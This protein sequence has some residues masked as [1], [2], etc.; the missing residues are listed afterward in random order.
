M[1]V[2]VAQLD[3]AVKVVVRG[4]ALDMMSERGIV[5]LYYASH[6]FLKAKDARGMVEHLIHHV[7]TT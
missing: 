7:V 4:P 3:G 2:A 6:L 1:P 5:R